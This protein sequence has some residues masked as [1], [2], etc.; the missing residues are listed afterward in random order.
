MSESK[1][2]KAVEIVGALPKDG[3]VKPSQDDQLYV[4]PL[5]DEK[6]VSAYV[7]IHL[8]SFTNTS[9]KVSAMGRLSCHRSGMRLRRADVA[10]RLLLRELAKVGDNNT[11]RP[12]MLDFTGKAK[13]D[14]W[15]SVKGTSKEEAYTNYV[16]KLT[17]LLE[18]AGDKA[19]VEALNAA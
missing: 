19:N 15:D 1:F 18:K 7:P 3:P 10:L 13:W 5:P 2:N 11:T 14:A 12:G 8:Q 4:S 17:E 6:S 16:K 9:S